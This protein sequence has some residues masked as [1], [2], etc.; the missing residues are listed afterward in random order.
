MWIC[1]F[2]FS[3]FYHPKSQ[4]PVLFAG[5]YWLAL[6]KWGLGVLGPP[7]AR[8]ERRWIGAFVYW[9]GWV[10][11]GMRDGKNERKG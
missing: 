2:F 10:D 9:D 5:C 6:I 8:S 11:D 4:L 7:G 3:H 1:Y